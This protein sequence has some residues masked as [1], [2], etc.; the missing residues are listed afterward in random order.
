MIA[1]KFEELIFWQK[2]REL[3]KIVYGYSKNGT[4]Q[5]GL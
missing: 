4:F 2:S 1:K 5:K 3:T